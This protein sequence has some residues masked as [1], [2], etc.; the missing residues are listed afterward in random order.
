MVEK[1]R[2]SCQGADSPITVTL[3]GACLW[4]KL[5]RIWLGRPCCTLS[6]DSASTLASRP[7][8]RVDSK[9]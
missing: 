3:S 7:I 2:R 5:A 6:W 4:E 9:T 8:T 1:R